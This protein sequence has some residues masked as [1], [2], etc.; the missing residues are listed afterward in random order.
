MNGEERRR[1]T[2]SLELIAFLVQMI[3]S[4]QVGTG[5]VR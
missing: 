2:T 5:R 3:V 4:W 1:E